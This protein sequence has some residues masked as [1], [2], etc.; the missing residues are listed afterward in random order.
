MNPQAASAAQRSKPR[1]QA[2]RPS[3]HKAVVITLIA[4]LTLAACTN[5][6]GTNPPAPATPEVTPTTASKEPTQSPDRTDCVAS[7]EEATVRHD[8]PDSAICLVVGATLKVTSAPAPRTGWQQ[9]YVTDS[10]VLDCTSTVS[11]DGMVNGT[12]VARRAG[13]ATVWTTTQHR[14]GGPPDQPDY[15]WR[16]NVRVVN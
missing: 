1:G 12:C 15:P 5:G 11:Q 13:E 4:T 3:Q 14:P 10:A 7:V 8:E 9:L 6:E 16:L 2:A